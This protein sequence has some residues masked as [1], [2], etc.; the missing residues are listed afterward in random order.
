MVHT[1]TLFVRFWSLVNKNKCQAL[2]TQ[3]LYETNTLSSSV[4][5]PAYL[6]F[7][8]FPFWLILH[9]VLG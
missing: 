4:V 6:H 1:W 9:F 7:L 3:R 8:P 2:L 5:R